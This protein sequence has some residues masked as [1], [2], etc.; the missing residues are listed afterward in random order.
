MRSRWTSYKYVGRKQRK[1][2][3]GD[4]LIEALFGVLLTAVLG[5]GMA[6][7]AGRV[8]SEKADM[9][10]MGAAIVQM[11]NLLQQEGEAL[12]TGGNR[13]IAVSSR[14]VPVRVTCQAG[15]RLEVTSAAGSVAVDEPKAIV[16]KAS[17]T[18]LGLSGGADVEVGNNQ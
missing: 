11:R 2:Q 10:I 9:K 8:L 7:V 18:D 5:A 16:L 3:R 1:S 6:H 17:A 15:A 14:T 12:C 4:V 13:T